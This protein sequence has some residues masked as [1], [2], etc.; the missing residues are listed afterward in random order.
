M[1]RSGTS[2]VEQIISNNNVV[3]GGGEL[4][5]IH[6]E[7]KKILD[8]P[9]IENDIDF[10]RER[11]LKKLDRFSDKNYIIDKLPLNF[12]WVGYILK[13]FPHAKII[14]TIRSYCK[15]FISL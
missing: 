8:S 7:L 9:T 1:P 12:L 13:I 15:L 5:T 10:V 6:E 4:N 3:F 2:L 14:H 11:Y